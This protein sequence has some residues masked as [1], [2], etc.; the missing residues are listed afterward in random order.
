MKEGQEVVFLEMTREQAQIV[1]NA[2]ELLARLHIGQFKEI[3]WQFIEKFSKDGHFDSARRDAVDDLLEQTCRMIFG[4]N[5]YNRP[6]IREKDIE[7]HRSW[8]VYATIRH[9]LAWHDRP[10]GNPWSVAFDK[11]LGYGEPMPKCEIKRKEN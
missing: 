6:D 9:A 7:H 2:T 11:P 10:E 5:M 3:T 4:V 8:A 1:M